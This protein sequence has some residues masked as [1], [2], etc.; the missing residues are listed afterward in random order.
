MARP[1]AW[2][3]SA[4][5]AS[6]VTDALRCSD[7]ELAAAVRRTVG[8]GPGLTPAGDDVIVGILAVLT[9]G[10]A[11]PAGI[12]TSSRLVCA[13]T[14]VLPSTSDVSRRLLDQAARGLPGRALHDLGKVLME[15]APDDVRTDALEL[16]LDT[17][18]TSGADA[19][20]G[21]TAACRLLFLPTERITI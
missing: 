15:G 2:A 17:G 8:R 4:D 7:A 6:D 18:Y 1:R 3:E 13:L 19:C 21:L 9:S 10:A 16:V 12:W 5:M 20:M 14:P 11:G